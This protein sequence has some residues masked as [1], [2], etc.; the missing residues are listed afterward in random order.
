MFIWILVM[1][2]ADFMG[3]GKFMEILLIYADFIVFYG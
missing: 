2:Y 3:Y 1:I